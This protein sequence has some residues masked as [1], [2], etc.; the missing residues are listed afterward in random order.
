[1]KQTKKSILS[2]ILVAVMMAVSPSAFAYK[3]GFYVQPVI[4]N[5][6]IDGDNSIGFGLQ[7]GYEFNQFISAES[8]FLYAS[9]FDSSETV[10]IFQLGIRGKYPIAHNFFVLGK[11]GMNIDARF[12]QDG[13]GINPYY[14]AGGGYSFGQLDFTAEYTIYNTADGDVSLI[15]ISGIY[16]F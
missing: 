11:G 3:T 1:M 12:T 2:A 5:F 10:S 15:S 6:T 7:S 9:G 14:G 8:G 4:G 13:L 16:E